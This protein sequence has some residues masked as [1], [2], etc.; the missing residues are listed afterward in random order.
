M[1]ASHLALGVLAG[2]PLGLRLRALGLG[3]AGLGVPD[4]RQR[5]LDGCVGGSARR[6]ARLRPA[7]Q[8]LDLCLGLDELAA[9]A[10]RLRIGTGLVAVGLRRELGSHP[11]LG[12]GARGLHCLRLSRVGLLARRVKLLAQPLRRRGPALVLGL[13][14]PLVDL[15]GVD[16]LL[17]GGGAGGV[18]VLEAPQSLLGPRGPQ[19]RLL[20]AALGLARAALGLGQAPLDGLELS[21]RLL[22]RPLQ[23]MLEREDLVQRPVLGLLS[24]GSEQRA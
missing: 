22:L 9:Q 12:L 17:L 16:Q 7:L 14:E 8:A 2:P 18:V 23:V 4:L 3:C 21:R 20:G 5:L 10:L 24:G 19:L 13:G 6:R 1:R 15:R 11:L